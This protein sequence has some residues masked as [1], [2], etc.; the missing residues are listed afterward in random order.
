M[1]STTSSTFS[2]IGDIFQCEL[3]LATGQKFI[4]PMREDGYIHATALCKIAGKK[5][6][7]WLSS[8]ETKQLIESKNNAE[9]RIPASANILIPPKV[10]P[11]KNVSALFIEVYKGGNDK[12]NQGTWVH[13]D[14]GIN[15]AQWCCPDFSLQVSRW[16][17]ELIIVGRVE[18]GLEKKEE[19]LK[20]A[21]ESKISVLEQQIHQKENELKQKEEEIKQRD[22][23]LLTKQ[24]QIK[25]LSKEYEKVYK[26]HQSFLRR[27]E[28]YKLRVGKCIYLVQMREEDNENHTGWKVGGTN[29]INIR[30]S[31]FRTSNPFAK[32]LYV[33][34]TDQ[35]FDLETFIK[36]KHKT[37]LLLTNREFIVSIPILDLIQSIRSTATMLNISFTEETQE[38]ITK[39]NEHIIKLNLPPHEEIFDEKESE[40]PIQF[41][42]CG[43]NTHMTEE[44]RM[45]PLD[46]F[47]KN[48][49]N[50]DG[51]NRICKTCFNTYTY[52]PNR[53][54]KKIVPIPEFDES[55]QK[56]CNM[57]EKVKDRMTDFHK[58]CSSSDGLQ[59]NC[60]ACKAHQKSSL[61]H[62]KNIEKVQ[63][64]FEPDDADEEKSIILP[65]R[66]KQI[67][68]IFQMIEDKPPYKIIEKFDKKLTTFSFDQDSTYENFEI[69][70]LSEINFK[71]HTKWFEKFLDQSHTE[72]IIYRSLRG[73]LTKNGKNRMSDSVYG[74]RDEILK[75]SKIYLL[76]R[77]ADTWFA[78]PDVYSIINNK[79]S[80]NDT[81]ERDSIKKI[82]KECQTMSMSDY[83]EHPIS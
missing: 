58:D 38:E 14:L 79:S 44:S 71:K 49:G 61:K 77:F 51:V 63:F 29:D 65:K 70:F 15:L 12:Y 23:K 82:M 9:A 40:L 80:L 10:I 19:D 64:T 54:F 11:Q 34:Y 76:S 45:L 53:K 55:I 22:L 3:V 41:K 13:P 8:K 43:G 17:R 16:I 73:E 67:Y 59:G 35:A 1:S 26:N 30:F 83:Y 5:V 50:D 75:A 31:N 52:G 33:M 56:W 36:L 78:D 62:K 2:K 28:L 81:I 69:W 66:L 57:C 25:Y 32:L 21:Y 20:E 39:F 7:H 60:K 48:S 6:S 18:Q 37:N 46:R 47:F 4:I 74:T 42:R 27:K 72:E 68:D 24:Q